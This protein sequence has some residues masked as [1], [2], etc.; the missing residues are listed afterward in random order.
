MIQFFN[1]TKEYPRT[2]LALSDA[3]FR[4]HKGEFA[5]LTGA[6]GAGKSTIL[7][8][9]YFEEKPTRG[10]IRVSGISSGEIRK[11]EIA[12]LRRKLGIV[13]QDFRLL[14]DRTAEA[15]VAF[16]LE[17]TGV[18]SDQIAPRVQRVLT[19]VGLASKTKAYPR[20][21]SGG[22]QQRVAIA[23]ALVNDPFVVIADEPTGNLD[24]RA[25]RSVF[26]LLRDINASGTAVLMATHNLDLVRR[27][28]Y[29][30]ITL[31]QGRIIADSAHGGA[32]VDAAPPPSSP[33]ERA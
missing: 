13:F 8:L 10:E 33:A 19:Q 18:R 32:R 28:D 31:D 11:K 25:T 27:T 29:R 9:A 30:T 20:E 7:R 24:E 5:F 3:T 22:E 16:A 23:R 14:E 17:V 6:S 4:L 1:V 26:Q 15:N 21:L 12:A 2:G